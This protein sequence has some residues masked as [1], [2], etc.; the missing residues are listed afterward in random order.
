MKRI[1]IAIICG[2]LL[3]SCGSIKPDAPEIDVNEALSIPEQPMS[4]VKVPVKIDLSPYFKATNDALPKEFKGGDHPCDGVSY[5]Y[6]FKRKPIKFKGTGAN[7][8][9][10]VKGEY[11]MK[12]NYCP[13]CISMFGSAS[14][15]ITSRL[16]FSCGIGEPMRK[17]RV[18]FKSKIGVDE[19]YR[20]TSDTKLKEV[21]AL[22]PCKVTLFNFDATGTLENEVKKALKYVEKD[23]DR[24][25]EDINLKPDMQ[26]TWDALEA[27]IDLEG[28]G[29]MFLNPKT[30]GMSD[31]RYKGDTAYVDAY[32]QA[33]PEVRLDTI[34]F[35][36]TPLP[37]LSDIEVSDGF[38]VKMDITA[39]YDSLSKILTRDIKGMETEIGG[40]KVIFGDVEV[41]GAAD[42]RLHIKV[43]FS[44]KKSG[45]LYLTGTP[46]FD[47]K[48]QR[49][50]FPDLEFDVK[51]KSALLKS[52]KWLFD[53]KVTSMIRDA[54]N[55]DLAEYLKS[56][57]A[58]IA[59]SLNGEIDKGVWMSGTVDEIRINYIYPREDAL[60]MR[61]S[62]TGHLG[63]KM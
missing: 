4:M 19:A 53:K 51:T 17:M 16:Y 36:P 21:K 60:F 43:A 27:P 32:L 59:E 50:S 22:S 37:N 8:E 24:A 58:T 25:I 18:A 20:L 29:F 44:G 6:Y 1:L 42:H 31:I 40:K 57:K 47:A 62:S 61:V 28:Y 26:L 46:E 2:M 49:I 15:C 34:G 41:H 12:T 33:Y 45:T 14:D 38:D 3:T 55:L 63:I 30:V 35:R 13:Q 48:K 39:K 10:S 9:Y 5:E 56:F 54:A 7:L 52:A 11:W 23:I